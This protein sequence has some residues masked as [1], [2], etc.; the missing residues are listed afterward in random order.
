MN[1]YLLNERNIHFDW[2][3]RLQ[4]QRL[5]RWI[6]WDEEVSPQATA[7]DDDLWW[8]HDL[9]VTT[10]SLN[11]VYITVNLQLWVDYPLSTNE[12][13]PFLS[14]IHLQLLCSHMAKW[15]DVLSQTLTPCSLW[16]KVLSNWGLQPFKQSTIRSFIM[17]WHFLRSCFS[18]VSHFISSSDSQNHNVIHSCSNDCD[19]NLTF[20]FHSQIDCHPF[21]SPDSHLLRMLHSSGLSGILP[22]HRAH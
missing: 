3:S 12:A 13:P 5:A 1:Q 15:T 6:W 2:E 20:V 19:A 18:F 7:E 9:H 8:V 4:T 14:Q 11:T 10:H 22:S 21:L 17:N 16:M